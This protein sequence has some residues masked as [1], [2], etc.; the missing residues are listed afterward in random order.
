DRRSEHDA[1][2]VGEGGRIRPDDQIPDP[3]TDYPTAGDTLVPADVVTDDEA[4]PLT[5]A[6]ERPKYAPPAGPRPPGSAI[7]VE[8]SLNF[9]PSLK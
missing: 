3:L 1:D 8:K 6:P 7:A 2:R 5:K 9:G 4:A